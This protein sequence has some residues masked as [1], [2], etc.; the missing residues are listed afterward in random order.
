MQIKCF[1]IATHNEGYLQ[2]LKDSCTRNN[3]KLEILGFNEKYTGHLFKTYKI[4][5]YLK[6]QPLNQLVLFIDGFDSIILDD[7]HTIKNNFLNLKTP[8]LF[9]KDLNQYNTKKLLINFFNKIGYTNNILFNSMFLNNRSCNI[10]KYNII[11]NSGLF[12]GYSGYLLDIFEK[13]LNYITFFN[14]GSNQRILQ[15]MCNDNINIYVDENNVIFRNVSI[16]DKIDLKNN[17]VYVNGVNSSIISF[18]NLGNMDK[19]CKYLNY[20]TKKIIKRNIFRHKITNNASLKSKIIL[21]L[22]IILFAKIFP[23]FQMIRIR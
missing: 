1:T 18:P 22:L 8:F 20:D 12:I 7:I 21:I 9:S 3:F 13:S 16:Y 17:K 5:Q 14:K 6:L 19:I 4:I 10:H 23:Y 2:I 11:I 15:D